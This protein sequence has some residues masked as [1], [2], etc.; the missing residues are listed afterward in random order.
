MEERSARCQ[1]GLDVGD[2][3]QGLV[4]DLD[5]LAGVLSGNPTDRGVSVD[6][7]TLRLQPKGRLVALGT[8]V[9]FKVFSLG[10]GGGVR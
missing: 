2:R 7:R 4:V 9:S 1:G 6:G 3:G 8:W 5:K 10:M